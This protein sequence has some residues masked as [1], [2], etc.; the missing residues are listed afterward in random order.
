MDEA[1]PLAGSHQPVARGE[2]R[3][4][5]AL[6]SVSDKRGI[7]DF[8]RGLVD[9][10]VEIVSTGGTARE[11]A[12]ANVPVRPIENFTGF[13]QIMDG[14]VKTLH[15]K[16]HAGL[17]AV[18][19][20]PD[21]LRAAE[22]HGVEFV[23]LVCVNLYPFERTAAERG[24]PEAA[25]IEQIDVG[26]PTMIRAA[27]KN[28]GHT[29]VVVKPESYDAVLAELREGDRRLSLQTR[30]NLAGEAFAYTA[31]YDTA[32]ARW[33]AEKQD[34]FP[35]LLVRAFEKLT[36]LPYGENP[37]QRAALY[38]QVGARM[39]LLSMV[40]QLGGKEL[41]FNNL[42]DIDSAR[43]VV[44]E[45]QV[46]ACVIVKHNNP[47][48]CAVGETGLEAYRRAFAG[49]PLSAFGGVICVNRPVD[50]A[51]AEAISNQFVEVVFAPSFHE[52]ALEILR[53]KPNVRI[54]EDEE[55]RALNPVDF[56][57]KRVMGGLLVQD[58]DLDLEDRGEMRVV[59]ERRP[60]AHEW[61]EMLFAWKVCKHV[62]SNAIVLC[63]DLA[64]VGIGAGQMS[65]VDSVR[66]AVEKAALGSLEQAALASDAY[67]P[68]ADG[69]QLAIEAGVTAIVQ[70]GGSMRD[71]EV[72]EAADAA[73]V[74][75]VFTSRRHFRH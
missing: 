66:L 26:G 44:N 20:N 8:A 19:D 73:G 31:R 47:C 24:V 38:T 10:G 33:F 34:D 52:E 23:D 63:K 51:L 43:T 53:R 68:F 40:R 70:P 16:L 25:V 39:H 15:A 55:R 14:R 4:A 62:R 60:T 64:T 58:R 61:E 12:G 5:R 69:P 57:F 3:I 72:V 2:V 29:A 18:R 50:A 1:A 65:R 22:E 6:L 30:E 41:S 46:P 59:T 11:L 54:L 9:L 28:F 49:D 74:T 21:H 32:V 7:V 56:D 42:L 75:M 48:G 36:D 35:P 37:H 71:H 67:F 27:A 17:L 45:F 13:P